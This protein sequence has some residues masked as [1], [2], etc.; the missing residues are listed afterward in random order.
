MNWGTAEK[1]FQRKPYLLDPYRCRSMKDAKELLAREGMPSAE[2]VLTAARLRVGMSMSE[3]EAYTGMSS[4]AMERKCK[5]VTPVRFGGLLALPRRVVVVLAIIIILATFMACTPFGRSLA[6]RAYNAIVEVID[7]ILYVRSEG[8][9]D[10]ALVEQAITDTDD[11]VI[12]FDS[13]DAML[14][15]V[16]RPVF[17]L[18]DDSFELISAQFTSSLLFGDQLECTYINSDDINIVIKQK[19]IN[20]NES[21]ITADDA[22][23]FITIDLTN[24]CTIEGVYSLTDET[25]V[26]S[27][28][29]DDILAHIL[30]YDVDA[31][32]SIEQIAF[33]LIIG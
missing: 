7:G 18:P 21:R 9:D 32:E 16:E 14:S 22:D 8:A 31:Y 26:G 15:Y 13:L 28:V 4:K 1:I 3:W 2:Q 30:I 25:F 6:V 20:K 19:W 29:D 17:S 33:S 27:I 11:Y 5:R 12:Q 23:A 10:T 24:G